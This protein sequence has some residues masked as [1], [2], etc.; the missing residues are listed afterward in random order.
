MLDDDKDG[1]ASLKDVRSAVCNIF[2][3]TPQLSSSFALFSRF[4]FVESLANAVFGS[5]I[6]HR[7]YASLLVHRHSTCFE[8]PAI[9]SDMNYRVVA[10]Q[11]MCTVGQ[12]F[13]VLTCL[14][15]TGKSVSAAERY[16]NSGGASGIGHWLDTSHCCLLR[17]P[18]HL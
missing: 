8:A 18:H 1:Q 9:V 14:Q 17:L 3:Y 16:Q 7:A 4:S 15:G 13:L 12:L 10:P 2:K 6:A 11:L 5:S